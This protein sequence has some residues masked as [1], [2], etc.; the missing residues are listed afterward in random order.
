MNNWFY[1]HVELNILKEYSKL[2]QLQAILSPN[3]MYFPLQHRFY[4]AIPEGDADEVD[5]DDEEE[6]DDEKKL[7]R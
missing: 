6:G 4:E 3:K 1:R 2:Q 7:L 5:S